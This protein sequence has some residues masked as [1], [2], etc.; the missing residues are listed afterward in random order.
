MNL[1]DQY[2]SFL[3]SDATALR[4][5][6]KKLGL[7]DRYVI[8]K[9]VYVNAADVGMGDEGKYIPR[10]II[11]FTKSLKEIVDDL[12]SMMDHDE[13]IRKTIEEEAV[14]WDRER[15]KALKRLMFM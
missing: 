3:E 10:T 15:R 7:Y 1:T 2:L 5:I 8:K 12:R 9:T 6:L 11:K 13:S 4:M 14:K